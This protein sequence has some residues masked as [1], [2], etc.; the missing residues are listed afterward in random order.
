[1]VCMFVDWL[2]FVVWDDGFKCRVSFGDYLFVV[3]FRCGWLLEVLVQF[4]TDLGGYFE[5]VC[6][7]V[8][9]FD[10]CLFVFRVVD[11]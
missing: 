4:L 11:L 8:G 5:V 9:G 6:L 7:S 1:M 3:L 10:L 2:S